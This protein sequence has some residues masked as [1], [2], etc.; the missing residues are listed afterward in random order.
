M[1]RALL[2]EKVG[3][4]NSKQINE[5]VGK[6]KDFIQNGTLYNEEFGELA[7]ELYDLHRE[8][9]P[10]Y[11]KYD[12]GALKDW[13]EIPLM[14]IGEFK[15]GR[16]GIQ[17][18]TEMP[19]PGV[20]FNSSGTTGRDKSEHFMY[21]T[22]TYRASIARGFGF[23]IG[24]YGPPKYRMICLTP[25]LKNSSLYYMMQYLSELYDPSGEF[26]RFD[27]MTNAIRVRDFVEDLSWQVEP[28]I[29]FGTS[30]AFYDLMETIRSLDLE[31]IKLPKNSL[32]ME[33]G[34]WKGR[35][36]EVTP[37]E[38]TRRVGNFFGVKKDD[39]IRE[40]SMSELS[41]QLYAWG[42]ESE[43]RYHAPEWL[44]Y[45]L[46]D[47]LSQTEVQ[48]GESGIIAFVDLAN[49]WSCPFILTEDVG[50][51]YTGSKFMES[52][53]LEGRAVNAPEKG[54]SLTYA[55]SMDR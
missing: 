1:E 43:V 5:I 36:I 33:T 25:E 49:V 47:P 39:L 50:H 53:V 45:R 26:E 52:L 10:I 19:Y 54:C 30:L 7:L 23:T 8:M 16:V 6:V 2:G 9:N 29:L 51:I 27:G 37:Q 17:W 41:S 13:R 31:S 44:N 4:V 12:K 21:D 18:E 55:Q 48:Q 20:L 3:K 46:V 38:L 24:D 14:P 22:E 34:G 15:N 40:Y 42:N 32:V 28:V 35:N 11:K